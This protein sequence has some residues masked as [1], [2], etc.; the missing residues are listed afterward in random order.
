M[1][2]DSF[3]LYEKDT[4]KI[5]T[6]ISQEKNERLRMLF[7]INFTLSSLASHWHPV[8]CFGHFWFWANRVD[9]FSV[10]LDRTIRLAVFHNRPNFAVE[11]LVCAD[12]TEV[13]DCKPF[14]ATFY[15]FHSLLCAANAL[16]I[17]FPTELFSAICSILMAK[18][19]L[20]V[21]KMHRFFFHFLKIQKFKN[22]INHHENAN[23]YSYFYERFVIFV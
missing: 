23:C 12:L 3:D 8:T 18:F 1:I 5:V 21:S 2:L 9:V 16:L 13:I 20:K 6:Y 17:L 22:N 14:D 4:V 10:C 19:V 15:V 7:V 11:F